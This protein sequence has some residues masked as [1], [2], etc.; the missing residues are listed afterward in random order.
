MPE[1]RDFV[2]TWKTDPH[3]SISAH[4]LTWHLEAGQL[5]G[6][7]TINATIE[8]PAFLMGRPRPCEMRLGRT[9]IDDGVLL[10]HVNGSVWPSEFRLASDG[11]AVLGAARHKFFNDTSIDRL[12][13]IGMLG[14]RLFRSALQ[15]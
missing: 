13:A 4:T 6:R 9:W 7:W 8:A 1:L 10:F 5:R 3:P 2:G 15:H 12:H 11:A 14:M